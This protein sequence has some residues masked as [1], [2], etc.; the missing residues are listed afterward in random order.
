[1]SAATHRSCLLCLGLLTCAYPRPTRGP[2]YHPPH[3]PSALTSEL[4]P[5][6]SPGRVDP[7]IQQPT[8][9]LA[10]PGLQFS[11]M[12]CPHTHGTGPG[13]KEQSRPLEAIG[14]M[15]SRVDRGGPAALGHG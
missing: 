4:G 9:R 6:E 8:Q 13:E 1:M 2:W 7:R 10:R 3:S 12:T 11:G 15:P 14:A 5:V